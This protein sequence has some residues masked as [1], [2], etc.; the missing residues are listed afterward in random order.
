MRRIFV[1]LLA[2]CG[3]FAELDC[4]DANCPSIPKHYEE[5]D[6]EPIKNE[7]ECCVNR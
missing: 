3:S 6:C 5:M 4:D 1:L 2:I 7:G